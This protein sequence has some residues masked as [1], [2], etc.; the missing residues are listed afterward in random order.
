[1]SDAMEYTVHRDKIKEE[2]IDWD[3]NFV[4]DATPVLPQDAREEFRRAANKVVFVK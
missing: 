4:M 1:M 3:W 2:M